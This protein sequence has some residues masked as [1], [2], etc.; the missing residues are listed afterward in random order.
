MALEVM[1]CNLER[2]LEG[3]GIVEKVLGCDKDLWLTLERKYVQRSEHDLGSEKKNKQQ[4]S[5]QAIK[6]FIIAFIHHKFPKHPLGLV[7][8]F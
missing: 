5:K 1:R 2:N 6:F 7:L 4:I 3:S 8:Q